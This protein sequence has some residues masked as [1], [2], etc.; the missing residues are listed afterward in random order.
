M[1]AVLLAVNRNICPLLSLILNFA[2]FLNHVPCI[3]CDWLCNTENNLNSFYEEDSQTLTED[4]PTSKRNQTQLGVYNLL[5]TIIKAKSSENQINDFSLVY[6]KNHSLCIIFISSMWICMYFAK[7]SL[8]QVSLKVFT[9]R[10]YIHYY[11]L[12]KILKILDSDMHLALKFSDKGLGPIS[13]KIDPKGRE[14]ENT[15]KR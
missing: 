5:S 6:S 13:Q 10:V 2:V 8:P 15:R 14:V 7:L 3:I 11:C 4:Q 9:L 1:A 12:S